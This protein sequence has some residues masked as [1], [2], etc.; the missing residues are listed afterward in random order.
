M[1]STSTLNPK[2]VC[3][4]SRRTVDVTVVCNYLHAWI[5]YYCYFPMDY[6]CKPRSKSLLFIFSTSQQWKSWTY[7]YVQGY[8][9]TIYPHFLRY[10]YL[11][12]IYPT[13][14]SLIFV[15]PYSPIR[16]DFAPICPP[17]VQL[18]SAR[19]KKTELRF[20][21]TDFYANSVLAPTWKDCIDSHVD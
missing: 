3:F 20:C 21:L 7:A 2:V 15:Q 16:P 17:F 9:S 8:L 11:S 14:L 18:R 19:Q 12:N 10:F 1:I 6:F 5:F 13:F 4:S